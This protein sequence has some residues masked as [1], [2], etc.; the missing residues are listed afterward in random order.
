MTADHV[1]E[2]RGPSPQPATSLPEGWRSLGCFQ[3]NQNDRTFPYAGFYKYDHMKMTPL[4]VD[5]FRYDPDYNNDAQKCIQYCAS[6]GYPFAGTWQEALSPPSS[7]HSLQVSRTHGHA[8][9]PRSSDSPRHPPQSASPAATRRAQTTPSNPAA[10]NSASTSTPTTRRSWIPRPCV[11][12][13]R[14]GSSWVAWRTCTGPSSAASTL[15]PRGR[16]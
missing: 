13:L 2:P 9:A 3:D 15:R 6:D 1:L 11:E 7:A 12:R 10:A 16:A 8:G 4:K 14:I 5:D